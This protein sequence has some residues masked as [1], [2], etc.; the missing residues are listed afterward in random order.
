[1]I[2]VFVREPSGYFKRMRATRAATAAPFL[3]L[4]KSN[5]PKGSI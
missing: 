3:P 5:D 2:S 4:G 1:M